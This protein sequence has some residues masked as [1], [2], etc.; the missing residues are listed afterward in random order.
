MA[1]GNVFNV[2]GQILT[3]RKVGKGRRE[4]VFRKR[5]TAIIAYNRE[6]KPNFFN[7]VLFK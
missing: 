2:E 3:P 6:L 4:I 1:V 7:K 5:S